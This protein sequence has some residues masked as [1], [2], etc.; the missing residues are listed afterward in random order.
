MTLALNDDGGSIEGQ[1][2][3]VQVQR[4]GGHDRRHDRV[5][6]RGRQDRH[7]EAGRGQAGDGRGP[8]LGRR[9]CDRRAMGQRW[10]GEASAVVPQAA[11]HQRQQHQQSGKHQKA[12]SI[13]G[14][15]QMAAPLGHLGPEHAAH[16]AADQHVGNGA[17]CIFGRC[18]LGGGEAVLLHERAVHTEHHGRTAEQREADAADREREHQCRRGCQQRPDNERAPATEPARQQRRR[19]GGRSQTDDGERQGQRRQRR[20]RGQLAPDYAAD[21]DHHRH[22]RQPQRLRDT[23]HAEVEHLG[24]RCGPTMHAPSVYRSWRAPV[25]RPTHRLAPHPAPHALVRRAVS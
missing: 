18:A 13:F 20:P 1:A 3:S 19:D 21:E 15:Q 12:A 14:L 25:A 4:R 10:R 11:D 16:H 8:H 5:G 23:E 17:S 22:G 24:R 6:D 9:A 7:A 2:D